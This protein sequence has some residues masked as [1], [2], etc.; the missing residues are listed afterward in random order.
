MIG[1]TGVRD[2]VLVLGLIIIIVASVLL[3][4]QD[5]KAR[6]TERRMLAI[7][8]G[9]ASSTGHSPDYQSV[10]ISGARL[11]DSPVRQ[12]LVRLF[13]I[14]PDIAGVNLIPWPG[15]LAL[16]LPFGYLCFKIATF[17]LSPSLAL[18]IA[19]GCGFAFARGTFGWE[20]GRYRRKLYAQMPDLIELLISA[21]A[22]GLP[23]SGAFI[24]VAKQMPH[25]TADEFAQVTADIAVGRPI[26]QALMRIFERTDVSEYAI[27]ATTVGLQAEVG[28]RIS[29]SIENLAVII[30]ERRAIAERAE[31]R[32]SESKLSS[33]ILAIMP[34]VFGLVMSSIHPGYLDVFITNPGARKLIIIAILLLVFGIGL[35]RM[36][37]RWGTQD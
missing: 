6:A 9:T 35:M 14:K 19:I 10:R 34:G 27:L 32:A 25:P 11:H 31:A 17:L 22:A 23:V 4:T 13:G 5:R 29:E 18:F 21:V 7:I 33:N 12:T 15:V 28:G 36:M 24:Q 3:L 2:S 30:R 26:D 16:A 1:P 8:H 37:V 20:S